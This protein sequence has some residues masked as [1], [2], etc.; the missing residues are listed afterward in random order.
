MIPEGWRQVPLTDLVTFK[1][2]GT[3][4]T[5]NLDYWEWGDSVDQC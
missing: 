3:P 1:S 4:S 5:Q 2:G